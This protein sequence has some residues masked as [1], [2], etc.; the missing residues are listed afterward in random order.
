[1]VLS[2]SKEISVESNDQFER[3][4]PEFENDYLLDYVQIKKDSFIQVIS[5]II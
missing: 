4:E 2:I 3:I 1:M 5:F